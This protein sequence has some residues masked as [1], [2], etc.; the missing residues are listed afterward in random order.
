MRQGPADD[1]RK[2]EP[3]LRR[4][5]V[6]SDPEDPR[7]AHEVLDRTAQSEMHFSAKRVEGAQ[8][9]CAIRVDINGVTRHIEK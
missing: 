8:L 7:G 3:S 4:P 9:A 1:P 6:G 2:L 5:H